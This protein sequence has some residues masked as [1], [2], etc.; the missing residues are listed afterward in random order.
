MTNIN[1]EPA[2]VNCPTRLGG[3]EP[4]ARPGRTPDQE[5]PRTGG[6]IRG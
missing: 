5:K 2:P 4:C 1:G 3:S 6:H